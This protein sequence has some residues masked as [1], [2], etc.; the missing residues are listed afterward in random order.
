ML[1]NVRNIDGLVLSR[2]SYLNMSKK[3]RNNWRIFN[4]YVTFLLTVHSRVHEYNISALSECFWL[5]FGIGGL[6]FGLL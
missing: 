6:P 4:K 1:N 2:N 3:I 5:K